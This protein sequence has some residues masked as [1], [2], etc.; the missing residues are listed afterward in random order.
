[1]PIDDTL[2]R[3]SDLA[4]GSAVTVYVLALTL[5]MVLYLRGSAVRRREES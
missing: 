1:M 4:F 3:Y 5:L 2:A